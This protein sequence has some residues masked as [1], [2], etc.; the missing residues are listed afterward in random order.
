[1]KKRFAL[2]CVSAVTMLIAL[3]LSAAQADTLKVWSFGEQDNYT[4]IMVKEFEAK[5]PD[6]KVE[7]RRVA[8]A[9]VNDEALRAIRSGTGPDIM[10]IE[11]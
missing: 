2:K 11:W 9:D 10:P 3:G 1:M 8:F 7:V 6:I 4:E 5:N